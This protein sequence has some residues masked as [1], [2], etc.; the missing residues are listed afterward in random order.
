MTRASLTNTSFPR[1]NAAAVSN[2]IARNRFVL[3][4]LA[5]TPFLVLLIPF[6]LAACCTPPDD[7]RL[8]GFPD[9]FPTLHNTGGQDA[10]KE[11]AGFGGL[12][13]RSRAENRHVV[14]ESDK[15]VV[16]LLHGN[17][18]SADYWTN[19]RPTG[20][21]M[22]DGLRDKGY[23]DAHIWAVSYQGADGERDVHEPARTNIADVRRF[24]DAVIEYTDVDKVDLL[25]VS[26]GT[27][28]SRGYVQGMQTDGSFDPDRRRMD[29]VGSMV[30]ITGANYGLGD[31]DDKDWNS[32]GRLYDDGSRYPEV[33]NNLTLFDGQVNLTPGDIHYYCIYAR[34]DFPQA[35]YEWSGGGHP[36]EPEN[37]SQ[38]GDADYFEIPPDYGSQGFYRRRYSDPWHGSFDGPNPY[39]GRNHRMS[40]RDKSIFEDYIY[41]QLGK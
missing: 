21:C 27:H 3:L 29:R 25:G 13:D 34:Y 37:T 41:P 17:G 20:F 12:T 10:G 23:S 15:R 14:A 16:V 11:L 7:G 36:L 1:Y 38:L 28:M 8:H 35:L 22:Y 30:L 33:Q 9:D 32:R 4:L 19:D 18:D 26:M 2:N 39:I 5:L 31:I 24:I 6:A 40:A